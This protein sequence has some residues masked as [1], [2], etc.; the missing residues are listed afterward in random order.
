MS[1]CYIL[2]MSGQNSLLMSPL[3]TLFK[4]MEGENEYVPQVDS[5]L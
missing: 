5:G 2:K 3:R 4:S 1:V